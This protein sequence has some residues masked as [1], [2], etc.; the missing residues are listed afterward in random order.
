[1]QS[2]LVA[3]A[4]GFGSF[5]ATMLDNF[6]AFAA[7][8]MVTPRERHQRVAASHVSGVATLIAI[9]VILGGALH[10]LPLWIVGFASFAPLVMAI[11]AWRGKTSSLQPQRRGVTTTFLVT[12]ALGGDNIAVWSPILRGQSVF[13]GIVVVILFFVLDVALINGAKWLARHEGILKSSERV[14]PRLTPFIYLVIALVVMW[15]CGWFG[16]AR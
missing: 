14:A 12:V 13:R 7:Q 10:S 4:V 3:L 5:L 2:L 16:S 6:I 1:M 8:L 15:Q 11:H 9:S